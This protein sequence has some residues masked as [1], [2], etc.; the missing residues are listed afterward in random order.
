MD[1]IHQSDPDRGH[2]FLEILKID[3]PTQSTASDD[4]HDA[5]NFSQG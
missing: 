3:R 2:L 4:D 1:P 5:R